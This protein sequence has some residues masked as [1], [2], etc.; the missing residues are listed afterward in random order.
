[1]CL[2]LKV[3]NFIAKDSE[4]KPH[5]LCLG[6][7]S[8]D[9]TVNNKKK[10]KLNGYEYDF[11]FDCNTIDVSGIVNICKYLLKI[12]LSSRIYIPN[13]TC[14]FVFKY[15]KRLYMPLHE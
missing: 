2:W 13:N 10:T 12:I 4:I 14:K 3:Y 7:L 9:F 5:P 15:D 11:Y 8:K 1:M 6:N